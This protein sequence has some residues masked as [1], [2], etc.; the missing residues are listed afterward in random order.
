MQTLP[1]NLRIKVTKFSG[2]YRLI[3]LVDYL[4]FKTWGGL[5]GTA[6]FGRE[7]VQIFKVAADDPSTLCLPV[8]IIYEN[9]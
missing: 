9:S 7:C 2:A 1:K 4:D 3:L 6:S 5:G 8:I